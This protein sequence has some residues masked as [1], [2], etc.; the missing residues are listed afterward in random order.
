MVNVIFTAH[1]MAANVTFAIPIAAG[2]IFQMG[3]FN[4]SKS[5][6]PG[7]SLRAAAEELGV[8][9]KRLMKY[10]RDGLPV[11][12][13][14]ERVFVDV[15]EARFWLALN[16][17]GPD[18]EKS[19][20]PIL[21]PDDPRHRERTAAARLQWWKAAVKAGVAV[22]RKAATARYAEEMGEFRQ[23][24]LAI[25]QRLDATADRDAIMADLQ[26]GIEEAL[27]CLTADRLETWPVQHAALASLDAAADEAE[28][29]PDARRIPLLPVGD[30][31][32]AFALSQAAK[33][34]QQLAELEA[35]TVG[36]LGAVQLAG[37]HYT[38]IRERVRQ[39]PLRVELSDS[40]DLLSAINAELDAALT[41]LSGVNHAAA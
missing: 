8:P 9:R 5:K 31:R 41:D 1:R 33:R 4:V 19:V 11:T 32:H 37:Q 25:A 7:V 28:P 35:D 40:T 24:Y 27:A 21:N 6:H 14:S 39:V 23:T 29:D 16:D 17:L 2:K 15:R 38:T 10:I 13:Q 34:E 20:A 30:P 26:S 18:A 12:R 36:V 3:E 22:K